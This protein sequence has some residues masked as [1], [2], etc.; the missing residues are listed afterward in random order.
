MAVHQLPQNYALPSPEAAGITKVAD[1]PVNLSTGQPNISIPLFTI[2]TGKLTLPISISYDASGI[3]VEQEAS[4]VGLG[5][6]LNA[7]GAITRTI[8]DKD[9][10]LASKK[11]HE[12]NGPQWD[13]ARPD[14]NNMTMFQYYVAHGVTGSG[15]FDAAPDLFMYNLC[16]MAGKFV[17]IINSGIKHIPKRNIKVEGGQDGWKLVDEAGT[18]YECGGTDNGITFFETNNLRT[19][20]GSSSTVDRSHI[21][22]WFIRKVTSAEKNDFLDFEYDSTYIESYLGRTQSQIYEESRFDYLTTNHL[23]QQ[24]N[25]STLQRVNGKAIKRISFNSGSVEFINSFNS[26]EDL[27][28]SPTPRLEKIIVKNKNGQVIREIKFNCNYF[29]VNNNTVGTYAQKRLKLN[30]VVIQNPGMPVEQYTF[31]YNSRALPAKNSFAQDHWGYYN[32]HNENAT[33]IPK[34]SY[35]DPDEHM[36]AY[37]PFLYCPSPS[38]YRFQGAE[39]GADQQFMKAG[40]LKKIIYPT[41]G[42]VTFDLEAH[43][44]DKDYD[45][46]D[47]EFI[48]IDTWVRK[49]SSTQWEGPDG[50]APVPTSGPSAGTP[51]YIYEFV[52]PSNRYTINGVYVRFASTFEC[53]DPQDAVGINHAASVAA[54]K[55]WNTSGT[56]I[57]KSHAYAYSAQTPR[58]DDHFKLMPGYYTLD[59]GTRGINFKV[60]ASLTLAIPTK[61]NTDNPFRYIG[62]LRVKSITYADP[63]SGKLN[64]KNYNYNLPSDSAKSSGYMHVMIDPDSYKRKAYAY[65]N[66]QTR[67]PQCWS[68][69]LGG[70]SA[71]PCCYEQANLLAISSTTNV[72]MG[73]GAAVNYE[74]VTVTEGQ[75]EN[76]KEVT[77][78]SKAPASFL[79]HLDG[80]PLHIWTYNAANTLVQEAI[81]EYTIQPGSEE[82]YGYKIGIMGNHPC[83]S[84]PN[85]ATPNA[86]AG[87]GY[88]IGYDWTPIRMRSE[89][90]PLTKRATTQYFDNSGPM[91]QT[92]EYTY[93]PANM[94]VAKIKTTASDGSSYIQHF[95]YPT[96]YNL[97]LGS[98]PSPEVTA[99]KT[100]KD[101]HVHNQV[102]EKYSAILDNSNTEKVTTGSYVGFSPVPSSLVTTTTPEGSF[103]HYTAAQGDNLF[104][105]ET[106]APLTAFQ[107]SAITVS[108]AN[109]SITKDN[110]YK[111]Q[112]S[113]LQ[114]DTRLNPT[115]VKNAHGNRTAL[116]WMHDKALLCAEA[117]N[118]ARDEV[119]YTSFED[120]AHSGNWTYNAAAVG[121]SDKITG[122]KSYNLSAGALSCSSLPYKEYKVSYWRKGGSSTVNGA[123]PTLTGS[124]VNGW[125]YCEHRFSGAAITSIT[126]SG[127]GLIDELRLYPIGAS[128]KTY[129]HTPLVG[130]NT[131]CDE[132]NNIQYYEYDGTGR[133][134]IVRDQNRNIVKKIDYG[135]QQPD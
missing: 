23:I 127:S 75:G 3:R 130:I 101:Q 52:I 54:I 7:G 9:D 121:S 98:I 85:P 20:N 67:A 112:Y 66:D 34:Y 104:T 110:A 97:S 41:G 116:L 81:N 35:L 53:P 42:S 11:Y 123:A 45:E 86:E 46:Y 2:N 16:G 92:E 8:R 62:G 38:L 109:S 18:I 128:M 21:V 94:E 71:I 24:A 61:L 93:D 50:I 118:A 95:K 63:V 1:I 125:V 6:S 105:L 29:I 119:A 12:I 96:S 135:I 88:E 58:C 30:S 32:G 74:Y 134:H 132:N 77:Q 59:V 129:C 79:S 36:A 120:A 17:N 64:V 65:Y 133:L 19:V 60:E 83:V 25:A 108:G 37:A 115:E 89:W 56:Q 107:P 87:G 91:T 13:G 122:V 48:D 131:T 15:G 26:R 70:W 4:A 72:E 49:L 51:R 57:I 27:F 33:L 106:T 69:G 113:I 84:E 39:R 103:T 22:S 14:P 73:D 43:A 114:Y 100:L 68:N 80:Q 10:Y 124:A 44:I 28:T 55:L 90:W 126:L 40:S 99:I 47:F 111:L 5:W 76:G 78:F 117:T 31:E 82:Y 102:V